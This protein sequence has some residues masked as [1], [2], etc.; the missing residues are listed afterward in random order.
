MA[1]IFSSS[2]PYFAFSYSSSLGSI[3]L[4]CLFLRVVSAI[5]FS[6]PTCESLQVGQRESKHKNEREATV[7]GASVKASDTGRE[8]GR[9][10]QRE[11][12]EWMERAE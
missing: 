2:P 9:E 1:V 7:L 5:F 4:I 8:G 11:R 3:R 6:S 12:E 10:G